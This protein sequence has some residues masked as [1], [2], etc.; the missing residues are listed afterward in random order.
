MLINSEF[1]C[2]TAKMIAERIYVKYLD[3]AF[4]TKVRLFTVN[5]TSYHSATPFQPS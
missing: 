4:T 2:A 1:L 3:S 5:T